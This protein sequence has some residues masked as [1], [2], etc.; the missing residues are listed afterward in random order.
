MCFLSYL[1][2]CVVTSLRKSCF[3]FCVFRLVVFEVVDLARLWIQSS[4]HDALNQDVFG[5]IEKQKNLRPNVRLFKG[6]SLVLATWVT[7][8]QPTSLCVRLGESV[9]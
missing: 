4:A 5:N 6:V 7:V 3:D 1:L 8:K 9:L 2:F